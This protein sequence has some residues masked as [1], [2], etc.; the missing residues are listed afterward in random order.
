MRGILSAPERR[1][2][3]RAVALLDLGRA[4]AA[5]AVVL[6]ATG[7]ACAIALAGVAAWMIARAAQVPEVVAL[8]VSP[9]MVRLF[10]ISRSV[11]RY[12][13]RLASHDTALRGMGALRARLYEILASARADTVAGLR[14]GDVLARVGAD[15]DAVGDVVVRAYLPMAVAAVLGVGTT[16]A[17][18]LVYWPAGLIIAACLLLAG[19]GGPLLSIRSARLA[20]LA[21]QEGA[22]DLSAAAVTI[23]ESGSQLAVDSRLGQALGALERVERDLGRNRDRAARPAALAAMIDTLALGLAILGCL[24]VGVPAVALGQLGGQWLAVIVLLPLAAFEA[25]AALGPASVQLVRSAGAAG[26]IMELIDGARASAAEADRTAPSGTAAGPRGAGGTAGGTRTASGRGPHLT[27]RGLAV[28]WPGGP[29]LA[30][31]IDLDLTPGSRL[32]LVGPSGIGKTTLM[33][34]LAG[35]LEPRGG[36]LL[37]DGAPPWSM[38]REEAARRISLTAE[39]AHVFATTVLENLRVA[40]GDV[41]DREARKLLGRA[42]LGAWLEGLPQGLETLI[43][44]GGSTLSGGERRRLLLARALAAPAPLMVLDEPGE[45]LDPA[46]ADRLVADLLRQGGSG[47]HGVMLVTHRLSALEAAQEVIV[48][49]RPERAGPETPARILARAGH[50]ELVRTH[51]PYRWSLEQEDSDGAYAAR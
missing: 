42:G 25:T 50:E 32:A 33:L 41:T 36:T 20:E 28:G 39:D 2:L 16:L 13:E 12:C 43:G 1:D 5:A 29:I 38:T 18:G 8:G 4:R 37:L 14:R 30:S 49:G 22:T 10:G 47:R 48:L 7:M 24:L 11:L 15:V 31:G 21:R 34:T 17:M 9:V 45:H 6:G 3:R 23:T 44:T 19:V 27:A 26:R 40:R 46:T 51:E 35:L